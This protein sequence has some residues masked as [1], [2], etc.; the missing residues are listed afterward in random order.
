MYKTYTYTHTHECVLSRVQ[1]FVTPWTVAS[2]LLCLWEFS[3]KNSGLGCCF[4]L[5]GIVLTQGSNLCLLRFLH[6]RQFLF[7]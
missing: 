1:L 2:G 6:C 7:C 5:Q 4:L 3:G